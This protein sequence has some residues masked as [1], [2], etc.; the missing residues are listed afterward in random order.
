[1]DGESSKVVKDFPSDY[2]FQVGL[3]AVLVHKA[4]VSKQFVLEWKR[5]GVG[6]ESF[7][8]VIFQIRLIGE[9]NGLDGE[10]SPG[11]SHLEAPDG[12][13]GAH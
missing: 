9:S 10:L 2:F 1:M 13:P 6:A 3:S 8:L 11:E 12:H 5:K 4:M 7:H